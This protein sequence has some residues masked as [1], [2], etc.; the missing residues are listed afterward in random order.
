MVSHGDNQ[1]PRELWLHLVGESLKKSRVIEECGGE[2]VQGISEL[3]QQWFLELLD[4]GLLQIL[5]QGGRHLP[6]HVFFNEPKL[7]GFGLHLDRV[8]IPPT[9]HLLQRPLEV[10][11]SVDEVILDLLIFLLAVALVRSCSQTTREARE[12]VRLLQE[13]LDHRAPARR[14]N[15][16]GG[17]GM[18]LKHGCSSKPTTVTHS[19][20]KM[21]SSRLFAN[22]AGSPSDLSPTL[23]SLEASGG[24]G[25]Y[26]SVAEHARLQAENARMLTEFNNMREMVNM[27]LPLQD[28]FP[29]HVPAQA[30]T[31]TTAANPSAGGWAHGITPGPTTLQGKLTASSG[32][33]ARTGDLS[34]SF[35]EVDEHGEVLLCFRKRENYPQVPVWSKDDLDK[36]STNSGITEPGRTKRKPGRPAKKNKVTVEDDDSEAE[37]APP[38]HGLHWL[39]DVHGKVVSDTRMGQFR[40]GGRA[41]WN[42]L[43]DQGR[44]PLTWMRGNNS[45]IQQDFYRHMKKKFPEF[46]LADDDWKIEL[47]AI[48]TYPGYVANRKQKFAVLRAQKAAHDAQTAALDARKAAVEARKAAATQEPSGGKKKHKGKGKP[49]NVPMANTPPDARDAAKEADR[50]GLD[51]ALYRMSPSLWDDD[52]LQEPPAPVR[53][54]KRDI[55]STD[56]DSDDRA[57]KRQRTDGSPLNYPPSSPPSDLPLSSPSLPPSDPLS[58]SPSF[59]LSGWPVEPAPTAVSTPEAIPACETEPVAAHARMS[60]PECEREPG[61]AATSEA[62]SETMSET[63]PGAA[64][65][66]PFLA[67]TGDGEPTRPATL[68]ATVVQNPLKG[69]WKNAKTPDPAKRTT[70]PYAGRSLPVPP[71]D[72]PGK[73]VGK[74]SKKVTS[75]RPWPP[76]PSKTTPK[77]KCAR[78][79]SI[80]HPS[81][82]EEEFDKWFKET[83]ARSRTE[84]K[85][86][87]SSDARR[88]CSRLRRITSRLGWQLEARERYRAAP[89]SDF[90]VQSRQLARKTRIRDRRLSTADS[91]PLG[92][93]DSTLVTSRDW[94]VRQLGPPEL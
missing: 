16:K 67:P 30:P 27:L 11:H 87:D 79:W 70:E 31:A 39:T 38:S 2:G 88:P 23:S 17:W 62:A 29:S 72:I 42:K 21:G 46:N 33:D 8:D 22:L 61:P 43:V 13:S 6:T 65:A 48:L 47:W 36:G 90:L 10:L 60:P 28:A 18:F 80:E 50:V 9:Q 76:S 91:G 25:A 19:Q 82:T 20:K 14:D 34:S 41:Y 45:D 1:T 74:G 40:N 83:S 63:V 68:A 58:S 69:M 89:H 71:E 55:D 94:L 64:T 51:D 3:L 86:M 92:R 81:G 54:G 77:P 7:L 78:L 56:N 12:G 59:S 37:E 26:V 57:G 73:K 24:S 85:V 75:K 84:I 53:I 49:D 66:P 52:L 5:Q 44:A 93:L 15:Q 32:A 35:P 4:E